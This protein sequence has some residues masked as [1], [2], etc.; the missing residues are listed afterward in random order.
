MRILLV[1]GNAQ[2]SEIFKKYVAP[3]LEGIL[4]L[5]DFKNGT[6]KLGLVLPGK[7]NQIEIKDNGLINFEINSEDNQ[8]I[9]IPNLTPGLVRE[10]NGF[11]NEFQPDVVHSF[12]VGFIGVISQFF[13]IS[14][15]MPFILSV[16]PEQRVQKV[17]LTSKILG[18][19]LSQ[20]GV[21]AEFIRNYY[22]NSTA[23]I[24]RKND[25]DAVLNFTYFIGT[26]ASDTEVKEGHQLL[27]FYNK[28]LVNQ[29]RYLKKKSAGKDS[30]Q[31]KE[32]LIKK[33]GVIAFLVAG[34][35]VAGSVFAF[36][37]LKGISKLKI[38]KSKKIK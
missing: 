9:Q 31:N 16:I 36:T 37:A 32:K 24:G 3:T 35:A 4:K 28:L 14:K 1:S 38:K 29:K 8:E 27:D 17:G 7:R 26:I 34:A 21:S 13:A 6:H 15:K 5:E 25:L 23:L 11:L 33:T 18:A 20:I 22:N 10:V 2:E 19:L 30:E 12:D